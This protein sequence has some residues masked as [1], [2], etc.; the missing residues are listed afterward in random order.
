[1]T[2]IEYPFSSAKIRELRAG[3]MVSVTGR[4]LTGR[5]RLHRYLYEGGKC[6]VDI[7]GGAI[8]HCGPVVLRKDGVWVV[9][10]AGP[11]TSIRQEPYMAGIIERLRIRMII[12][13]GGMGESTRRAC[14]KYGCVYL[15]AVGGAAAAL[16]EN[17]KRVAGVHMLKEF[18]QADALWELV[19]EDFKAVVTMDTHGRSLHRKVQASSKR[20]LKR[21]LNPKDGR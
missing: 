5:D 10:A 1:M 3:E 2:K 17:I 12:G 9:R 8:Y 11:T 16:A 19:V 6:P 20:I 13:K 21:I 18:G 7:K 15:Q 14:M 4:I